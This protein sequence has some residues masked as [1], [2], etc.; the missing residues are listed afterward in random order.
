MS[1]NVFVML[2]VFGAFT[3]SAVAHDGRIAQFA[4]KPNN[5]ICGI[6]FK[7]AN[8]KVRPVG[9]LVMVVL[10]KFSHHTDERLGQ[11]TGGLFSSSSGIE[12]A[13]NRAALVLGA[14]IRL[15]A[16]TL[17]IADG[18][19]VIACACIGIFVMIALMK[20]VRIYFDSPGTGRVDEQIR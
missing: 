2:A 7:P 3:N 13:R 18:F 4:Q 12:E 9:I 14:Q 1:G 19:T 5:G 15:Q 6:N 17:A 10:I 20:R 16:Y 8:G 11:L